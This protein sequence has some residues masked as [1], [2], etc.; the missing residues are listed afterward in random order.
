MWKWLILAA[1]AYILYRMFSN[2]I[3]RK[4]AKQNDPAEQERKVAS[5]EM[6]K[7]PECGAYVSADSSITVRDGESVHRFCSY[8]CR[9]K[10][11]KRL[12][13]G[14]RVIPPR[15]KAEDEE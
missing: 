2:D 6:V 3:K 1:A 9:D 11:L 4:F 12:E 5:G 14:G 7:D 15:P 10:F 8:D 13:D